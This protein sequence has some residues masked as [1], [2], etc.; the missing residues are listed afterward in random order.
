LSFSDPKNARN[1][2]NFVT[3]SPWDGAGMLGKRQD[4]AMR[5]FPDDDGMLT[6]EGRDFPK[7][8]RESVAVARQWRGAFG[9]K[10]NCQASVKP[11]VAGGQGGRLASARPCVPGEWLANEG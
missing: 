4:E 9:G 10:E 1:A 8:G 7:Q 5:H 6:G 3:R 2:Q 11:G